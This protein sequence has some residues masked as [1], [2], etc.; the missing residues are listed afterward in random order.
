M[1]V[2]HVQLVPPS[3]VPDIAEGLVDPADL[4]Y[5][6][7]RFDRRPAGPVHVEDFAQVADLAPK[8]KYGEPGVTY[9]SLGSAIL[10]LMGDFGYSEYI[11]R[12]VAMLVIGNTDAHLK[13]WAIIYPDRRTP[14]L[15]PIYDFHSL[16]VYTR[17][18][19]GPMALSLDG[20]SLASSIGIDSF[21]RLSEHC[22]YDPERTV[23]IVLHT[24]DRLRRAWTEDLQEEAE[25]RFPALARHFEIRLKSLPICAA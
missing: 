3:A 23:E 10:N 5:L 12:L 17:Y 7:E 2:P 11:E 13:N 20:E 19:Y 18:R 8:F 4:I 6:I 25:S 16:T 1:N 14:S 22:G 24:V 21:R 15:S 9:D